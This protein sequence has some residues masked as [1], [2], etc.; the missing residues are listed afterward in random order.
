M[1]EFI[2]NILFG[3]HLMLAGACIVSYC[4]TGCVF[5]K[6]ALISTGL[7]VLG[8]LLGSLFMF[9][10]AVYWLWEMGTLRPSYK[11]GE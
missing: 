6:L 5:F 11:K 9:A 3:L 2:K 7:W 8:P 10:M 4:V 1:K